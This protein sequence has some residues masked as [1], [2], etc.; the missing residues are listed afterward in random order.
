MAA[1]VRAYAGTNDK[2]ADCQL[3]KGIIYQSSGWRLTR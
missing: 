2:V 3:T 1:N